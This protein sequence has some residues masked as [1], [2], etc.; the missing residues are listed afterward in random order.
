M[1]LKLI[2]KKEIV[3]DK[4]RNLIWQH[5]I[6]SSEVHWDSACELA[7]Q[8]RLCDLDGWRLP[9]IEELQSLISEKQDEDGFHWETRLWNYSGKGSWF[10]SSTADENG[11]VQYVAFS[12]GTTGTI[13]KNEKLQ[14]LLV[15]D[16]HPKSEFQPE[17]S[18]ETEVDV[19]VKNKSEVEAAE[20]TP[21]EVCE[22]AN[23][24]T[25]TEST[26][27]KPK[28]ESK[29]SAHSGFFYFC[30]HS[31]IFAVIVGIFTWIFL[32]S[33]LPSM[34][35]ANALFQMRKISRIFEKYAKS[36]YRR[37][38]DLGD[39]KSMAILENWQ[40]YGKLDE[41]D[42]SFKNTMLKAW[43]GDERAQF[44]LAVIYEQHGN[45]DKALKWYKK[46]KESGNNDATVI[47]ENWDEYR[48]TGLFEDRLRKN[49]IQ[50]LQGDASAQLILGN[51]YYSGEITGQNK[52]KACRWWLKAAEKG[53][54]EAQYKTGNCYEAGIIGEKAETKN[55]KNIKKKD[56]KKED[57]KN[58]N[59]PV[60]SWLKAA[61]QGYIEAQNKIADCYYYGKCGLEK[62][63]KNA[64]K[65]LKKSVSK[66]NEE[67]R[68]KSVE[69]F[70]EDM[71]WSNKSPDTMSWYDAE[72]YCDDLDEKGFSDWRLPNID[73]LRGLVKDRKTVV[74]GECAVSVRKGCLSSECWSLNSCVEACNG[75]WGDCSAF[76]DGRYSKIGDGNIWFW[77]SSNKYPYTDQLWGV[78]FGYGDV[79]TNYISDS[80]YVRCVR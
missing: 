53:L 75:S 11:E 27:A 9:T 16:W 70:V 8:C 73:E 79:S 54:A 6:S 44:D 55:D 66:G 64:K 39:K 69:W 57:Q 65:W 59:E 10:W 56:G 49:Q 32:E 1:S 76:N 30:T 72:K 21:T 40:E 50:A 2:K 4:S 71:Q 23:A 80:Y 68:K 29:P 37:H 13:S 78:G 31:I 25:K 74:G 77:S 26:D 67:A 28:F 3:E 41:S 52:E 33:H 17:I 14:Y 48:S 36:A 34:E 22:V 61:E 58:E 47:V 38:A 15:H 35:T 42:T 62:S 24:E 45:F 46:A 5:N 7:A 18:Q 19:E 63:E 12:S 60:K 51:C 20:E 43:S